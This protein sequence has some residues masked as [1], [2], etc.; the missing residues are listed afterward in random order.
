MQW[1]I[2]DFGR[3]FR[4]GSRE[5]T[6]SLGHTAGG[7]AVEL[8]AIENIGH[9][10]IAERLGR[11]HIQC[12]PAIMSEKAISGLLYWL[13]DHRDAQITISWFDHVWHIERPLPM[14]VA[15]S[16]VSC[17]LGQKTTA[18]DSKVQKFLAEASASA[19]G[20]W[21]AEADI[22]MPALTAGLP[23]RRLRRLLDDAYLGR[24]TVVD[25]ERRSKLAHVVAHGE[26]YPPMCPAPREPGA[27]FQFS[28][29][30]DQNYV[31]WVYSAF[32]DA[33]N[34]NR[35]QFED[36]DAVIEWPLTGALRT[37][38]WRAAVP[39]WREDD[40]CRLLSISGNDSSINLRPELVQVP[41]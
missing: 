13:M 38:Y 5:L 35:P 18:A 15:I 20:R 36:V 4:S 26:G 8:Y 34:T 10:G 12:R 41:A 22:L 21:A 30:G 40:L 37:R 39:V 33:A 1:I 2:D 17:L 16:F 25:L 14:P 11:V 29:I 3:T 9:I 28:H 19:R 24:W 23:D 6:N 27:S 32:F 7:S 31:N